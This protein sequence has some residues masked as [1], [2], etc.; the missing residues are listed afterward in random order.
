MGVDVALGTG[1]DYSAIVIV[2]G[3]SLQPVYIYRDNTILPED[4]A[5]K[6]WNLYHEY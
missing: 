6:V 3:T 1:K 2:S 5:E 4:L